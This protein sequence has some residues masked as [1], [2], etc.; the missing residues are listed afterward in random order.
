[1]I[2]S[3]PL[4]W[5]WRRSSLP[6]LL[7]GSP[8][9]LAN[10]LSASPSYPTLVHHY[11][12]PLELIAVLASIRGALPSTSRR[13]TP[14]WRLIWATACWLAL[15]KPRFFTGPY[16]ERQSDLGDVQSAIALIQPND[17]VLNNSYFVAQLA[18]AFPKRSSR[19]PLAKTS[20]SA[21]LLNPKDPG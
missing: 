18:I 2:L 14:T 13:G 15:T 21:L 9:L 19:R 5:L 17:S 7:I 10:L 11:S 8:L 1:M 16:L 6:T 20:W 4:D 3:L 12:L